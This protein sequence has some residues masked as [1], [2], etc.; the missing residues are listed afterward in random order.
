MIHT[1][2][3]VLIICYILLAAVATSCQT[4]EPAPPTAQVTP[5]A[6]AAPTLEP[7]TASTTA[8]ST[9]PTT[10]TIALAP[11]T[12]YLPTQWPVLHSSDGGW[13]AQLQQLQRTHPHLEHYIQKL[14]PAALAGTK[15]IFAWNQ[16][17]SSN[18]I[19][20]AAITPAD[21]L[22]LQGYLS[23]ITEE[24]EQSRLMV[25]SAVTVRQAQM[26][27]DLHQENI[28]L[29]FVHYTLTPKT[30]EQKIAG[31]QAAMLDSKTD[32]LLLLTIITPD[33]V[34]EEAQALITSIF[35]TI[36]VE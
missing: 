22:T 26:Y 36:T 35:R 6:T 15:V 31:Y 12:I 27:Y 32:H 4:S 14:L 20:V 34:A 2:N 33:P 13:S 5:P 30:K 29:A 1:I 28:P 9:V 10:D 7:T 8:L 23:A 11:F 3:T 19:I 17:P 25:G 24:L 16:S 21:G 18:T